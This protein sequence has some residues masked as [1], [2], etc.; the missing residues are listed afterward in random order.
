MVIRCAARE[1]PMSIQRQPER[2]S[3]F[4]PVVEVE[5]EV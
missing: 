4:L 3:M 1:F 2:L 5:R